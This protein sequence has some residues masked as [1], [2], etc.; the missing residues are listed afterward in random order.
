M[1]TY[2]NI[3]V[4][5]LRSD[6]YGSVIGDFYAALGNSGMK[7]ISGFRG[8]E[9]NSFNEIIGWN[10]SK[11]EQDFKLG[12]TEDHLNDYRQVLFEFG[13]FSPVRVFI[14]NNYPEQDTFS[15]ELLIPEADVISCGYPLRFRADRIY[16]LIGAAELIWQLPFVQTIQTGTEAD[17]AAVG[18][19][20]L[21]N[22]KCA[23]HI[24]PFAITGELLGSVSPDITAE[25]LSGRKGYLLL[26]EKEL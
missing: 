4:Q 2:F 11:L 19:S 16:P 18:I 22:G 10:Q 12:Y 13:D 14:M 3:S 15:F 6:I 25:E 8:C 17:S 24:S 1:P 26:N 5:I 7:F 20:A 21:K 9:D 23:P